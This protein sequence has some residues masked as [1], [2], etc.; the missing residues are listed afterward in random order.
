MLRRWGFAHL[1][2]ALVRYHDTGGQTAQ[3]RAEVEARGHIVRTHAAWIF[4]ESLSFWLKEA[5]LV[6]IRSL[7]GKHGGQFRGRPYGPPLRSPQAT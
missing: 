7:L 4:R 2:E 1:P 6:G 3:W 5:A